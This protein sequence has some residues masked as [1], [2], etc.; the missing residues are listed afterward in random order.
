M[1]RLAAAGGISAPEHEDQ[2]NGEPQSLPA[3]HQSPNLAFLRSGLGSVERLIKRPRDRIQILAADA[4]WDIS[5][6]VDWERTQ[7]YSFGATPNLHNQGR[8]VGVV[9]P[10]AWR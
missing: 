5:D 1:P 4:Q 10:S 6:V 9:P 2:R 7:A 3:P 8:S